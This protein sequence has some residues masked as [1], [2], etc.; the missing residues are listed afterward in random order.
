MEYA[1]SYKNHIHQLWGINSVGPLRSRCWD[2]ASPATLAALDSG[3]ADPQRPGL[4][5]RKKQ[6]ICGEFWRY[7]VITIVYNR[8]RLYPILYPNCFFF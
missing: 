1:Q 4:R 3:S 6:E 8:Y 2:G 5:R 7:T